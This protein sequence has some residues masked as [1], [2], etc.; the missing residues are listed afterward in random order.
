MAGSMK[1]YKDGVLVKTVDYL[2][3]LSTLP[4]YELP[5][6]PNADPN[7]VMSVKGVNVEYHEAL[8]IGRLV[9]GGSPYTP[10]DEGDNLWLYLN[11]SET[12]SVTLSGNRA[13]QIDDL[14]GNDRHFVT[15]SKT[16]T[17]GP[18][19]TGVLQNGENVF[20][21][22]KADKEYLTRGLM[23]FPEDGIMFQCVAAS[24]SDIRDTYAAVLSA[25][26]R[27]VQLIDWQYDAGDGTEF[28][29]QFKQEGS[30]TFGTG[31]I[32]KADG[33]F[34]IFT[35]MWHQGPSDYKMSVYIDGTLINEGALS[36]PPETPLD[37]YYFTNRDENS[38]LSGS[39]GGTVIC[40]DV[41]AWQRVEGYWAH[42]YGIQDQ[43][44]ADHP[45]KDSPPS[46]GGLSVYEDQ[47]YMLESGDTYVFESGDTYIFEEQQEVI[48]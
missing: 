42:L 39:F 8:A 24:I 4:L 28:L 2:E 30:N 35:L 38:W 40:T 5:S 36:G 19:G 15:G 48:A 45:Y 29:G 18:I 26:D 43:L 13:T 20:V 6:L 16:T 25:G 21:F 7:A 1:I 41:D 31:P 11:T 44:P 22:E 23:A 3:E 34:H 33:Q 10:L 37:A 27:D 9:S 14:S 46:S 17:D 47:S 12:D 32:D